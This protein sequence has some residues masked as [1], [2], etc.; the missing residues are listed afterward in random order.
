MQAASAASQEIAVLLTGETGVGKNLLAHAIHMNS[1]RATGP[2]V[3]IECCAIPET[4]FESEVFGHERG[5]FTGAGEA[6]RG[7]IEAAAGGTLFL[8]EIGDLPTSIQAKLLGLLDRMVYFRI[9]GTESL[10]L[11]ARI[12]CATNRDL[13][14]MVGGGKFRA[15]LFYRLSEFT[16]EIP[17]LRHRKEDIRPLISH[18]VQEMNPRWV[19]SV[20]HL[21]RIALKHLRQYSWPGNVRELRHWVRAGMLAADGKGQWIEDLSSQLQ[22]HPMEADVPAPPKSL[23]AAE[24]EHIERTLKYTGWKKSEAA[25]LLDITRTTLDRKIVDYQIVCPAS[26]LYSSCPLIGQS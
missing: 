17:P 10:T 9:G 18:M 13:H 21:S 6:K 11:D 15:D 26:N 1:K 22:E 16:I 25:R 5:A 20:Q 24:R 23:R 14:K 7:R 12:V 19:K 2:M 3:E 8:D 4:L